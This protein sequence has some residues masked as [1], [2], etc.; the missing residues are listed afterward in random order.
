M[1]SPVM[2]SSAAQ[3]GDGAGIEREGGGEVADVG[4]FAAAVFDVEAERAQA[5]EKILVP[6]DEFGEHLAGGCGGRCG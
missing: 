1:F 3:H 5:A 4:G 6:G 2:T